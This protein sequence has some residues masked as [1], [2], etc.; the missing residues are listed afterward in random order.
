MATTYVVSETITLPHIT[1]E[2]KYNDGVFAAHRLTAHEGYVLVDRND[3]PEMAP[4]IDP[5][6]GD[7]AID[8]E[9][10]LVIE[11][12]VLYYYRQVTVNKNVPLENWSWEA[13]LEST[14]DEN[15]I[16]GLPQEKPEVM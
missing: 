6:T 10:G 1:V 15:Y 16:F 3:E 14:V 8:P 12:P 7:F 4:Q 11:V 5:E 2:E 13:V 9:T